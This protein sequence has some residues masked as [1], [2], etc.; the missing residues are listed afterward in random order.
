MSDDRFSAIILAA[1]YSSRMGQFKPLLPICGKT[2]IERA[3]SVFEENR[4]GD[5]SVVTGQR[6][7]QRG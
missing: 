7:I 4:I 3:I 6:H 2:V 1:G 5:I